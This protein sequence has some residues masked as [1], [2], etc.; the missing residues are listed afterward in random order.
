MKVII[1][2]ILSI[3][4]LFA[5]G[6]APTVDEPQAE[7]MPMDMPELGQVD[8][9]PEER[10]ETPVDETTEEPEEELAPLGSRLSEE[11]V[12]DAPEEVPE[13]P[14]GGQGASGKIR[15]SCR[16]KQNVD[17]RGRNINGGID[18]GPRKLSYA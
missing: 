15:P 8:N 12:A 18:V 11:E 9:T 13:D 1:T 16:P 7:I 4:L 5:L 6:C 3:V 2:I 14:A 10:V 17:R